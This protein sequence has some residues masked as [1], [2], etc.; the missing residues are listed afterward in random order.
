M[1]GGFNDVA[2]AGYGTRREISG[3]S[4]PQPYL[5]MSSSTSDAEKPSGGVLRGRCVGK[6]F[7]ELN[8]R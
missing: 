7:C 2:G 6:I 5:C 8:R 1:A 4:H 3:I